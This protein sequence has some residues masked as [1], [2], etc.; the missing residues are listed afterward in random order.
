MKRTADWGRL[1][2][3]LNE[4]QTDAAK[5]VQEQEERKAQLIC[6][7]IRRQVELSSAQTILSEASVAWPVTW[8]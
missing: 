5:L 2:L 4:A 3:K 7:A 8:L 6:R 1:Q